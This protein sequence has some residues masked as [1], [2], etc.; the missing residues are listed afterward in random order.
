MP[1]A[2]A[3]AT[4]RPARVDPVNETTS[5]SGCAEIAA[6]TLGTVAVNEV[7]HARWKTALIDYL[8]EDI[9]INRRNF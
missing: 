5:T 2:A 7:K 3:L 6:P 1:S 9:G 8:G 4:S